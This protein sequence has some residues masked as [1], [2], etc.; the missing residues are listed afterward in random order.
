MPHGYVLFRYL[1]AVAFG[2]ALSVV[3]YAVVGA[4]T[5]VASRLGMRGLKRRRA[6]E[7]NAL[8]A[9]VEPLVRWLGV[10]VSGLLSDS[11][12][13]TLDEQLSL[14]G[15]YLGLT[16]EEY[17]GLSIVS[18]VGGAVFGVLAGLVTGNVMLLLLVCAPMGGGLPYIR[19]SGEQQRRLKQI[20]R[21]LP[22]AI[23]LI[24]LGMSAGLDF[25][26]AIKQVVEKSSDPSDALIEELMRMLQELQLGRT[27]KQALSEFGTRAPTNSVSEFVSA[28]VQAEE[29]GNPV[30]EVLI[31][32]A[33]V[34]RQRRTVNAEE[35]AAKAGVAMVLPLMLLFLC[36]MILIVSPMVLKLA[37][38][39]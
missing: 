8:W 14:A 1:V 18:F 33:G 34:S 38:G 36:I 23:D 24:A 13:T 22:Y 10:R 35:A 27:R 7:N 25:P 19:I 17:V 5:R 16:P 4:P 2:S 39:L 12:R 3:T 15:D 37:K 29:R 21:G 31:I 26:G 9:Q 28:M 6:I 30:A 20:N 32:Q 11:L